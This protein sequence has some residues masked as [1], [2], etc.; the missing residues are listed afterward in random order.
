MKKFLITIWGVIMAMEISLASDVYIK[1]LSN[2][3]TLVVKEREDT[4][5][6]SVQVW[7]GIGSI[8]EKDNE[9]GISHFLEHMLFNGTKYT[10]PGE[11]EFEVEKKK[12]EG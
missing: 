4:K 1:K 2:G 7:F 6:V 8:Y 3:Y 12:V 10:K 5:A 11:I 9:R